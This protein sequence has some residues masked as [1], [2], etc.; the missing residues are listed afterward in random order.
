LCFSSTHFCNYA[1]IKKAQIK[2]RSLFRFLKQLKEILLILVLK[3]VCGVL[4]SGRD[5]L[6]GVIE[7]VFLGLMGDGDPDLELNLSPLYDLDRDLK[8]MTLSYL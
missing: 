2:K 6:S 4:M 3:A 5:Y 8:T 7:A 1:Q